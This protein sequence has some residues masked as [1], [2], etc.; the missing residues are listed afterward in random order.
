MTA[1]AG[2]RGDQSPRAGRQDCI[3]TSVFS[4][5]RGVSACS[6]DCATGCSCRQSFDLTAPDFSAALLAAA[7]AA[8]T[9]VLSLAPENASAHAC[10]GIV[11]IHTFR[12]AEGTAELERALALDR[13]QAGAHAGIGLAKS[14]LDR[15]Q[16]TEAHINALRLSPRDTAAYIWIGIAGYAK[17]LLTRD[18]EAVAWLHRAIDTN[19]NYPLAYFWLAA[20]L[21]H[22]G[23][24]DDA[25]AA[26]RAGLAINPTF[27]ISR[28]RAGAQ[29]DNPTY[30]AQR[31]HIYEGTRKAGVPEK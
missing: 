16:E 24:L 23:R 31:E 13:N 11:Q 19:R 10:M 30:L 14:F 8:L 29:S 25:R 26:S 2:L 20:A 18:E 17:L 21:A 27:T 3:V 22:L 6:V 12:A 5:A 15:A 28:Y 1:D 9:K 4:F 7:E